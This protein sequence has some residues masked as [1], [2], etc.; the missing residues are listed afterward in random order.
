MMHTYNFIESL[1][2]P[3]ICLRGEKLRKAIQGKTICITGASSGIGE[4]LA[5]FL[6]KLHIEIKLILVARRGERL[7]ALKQ[8]IES[9]TVEVQIVRADLRVQEE[10]EQVLEVLQALPNGLDIFVNNAG[11]SINRPVLKSLD[12]FHDFTRTM[13]INYFAPVQL[14]LHV[15]PML[16]RNNGHIINISTINIITIVNNNI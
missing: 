5:I 11:L 10:L 6:S 4:Q 8:Q 16:E 14:S 7:E 12:R 9:E 15:I 3:P 13:A 2:F 1:L